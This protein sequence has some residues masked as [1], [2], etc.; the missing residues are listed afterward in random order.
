MQACG[1]SFGAYQAD[2]TVFADEAGAPVIEF[3]PATARYRIYSGGVLLCDGTIDA[4]CT[5]WECPVCDGFVRTSSYIGDVREGRRHGA[6]IRISK[7]D[8]HPIA[9][10]EWA[11]GELASGVE[12]DWIVA[13]PEDIS[14][15]DANSDDVR[16][17]CTW[18][19]WI[20]LGNE[21]FASS[22]IEGIARE[23]AL[24]HLPFVDDECAAT[25]NG[26]KI[27]YVADVRVEGETEQLFNIRKIEDEMDISFMC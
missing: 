23:A 22:R 13:I 2:Q 10:G 7:R 1:G 9:E 12:F 21:F 14:L 19:K 16:I 20:Q 26:L 5:T 15:D 11:E 18:S 3:D 8:S 24:Q 27:L 4:D 17:E 6:G 25:L